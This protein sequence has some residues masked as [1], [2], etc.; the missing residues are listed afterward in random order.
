MS[1]AF[2]VTSKKT[3][4]RG[5]TRTEI[6]VNGFLVGIHNKRSDWF[7]TV[8]NGCPSRIRDKVKTCHIWHW[9]FSGLIEALGE[10]KALEFKKANPVEG[11]DFKWGFSGAYHTVSSIKAALQNF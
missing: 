9:N 3:V 8:K 2:K 5:E 7:C 1:N 11:P 10:E 6:F 4:N